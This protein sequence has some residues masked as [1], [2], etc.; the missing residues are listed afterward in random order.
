MSVCKINIIKQH[1]FSVV[2]KQS[3]VSVDVDPSDL[4]IK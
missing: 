4:A 1:K 2:S 3:Y